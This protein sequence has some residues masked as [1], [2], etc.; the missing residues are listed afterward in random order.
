MAPKERR[1][2]VLLGA[3]A[4]AGHLVL[5]T[6]TAPGDAPGAVSLFDP[7]TD[8]DPLAHREKSVRLA[9]PLQPGERV[10]VDR[11][12]AEEL[13]RLPGVGP[14]LARRIVADREKGGAFGHPGGLDRVP[15][16]GPAM[17]ARLQPW[18]SFGG[19]P[20]EAIAV[21]VDGLID[22]NRASVAELDALPG[23]GATRAAAIVAFRDS[24][25]PFR[26]LA[27]LRQVPGLPASIVARIAPLL[28]F[29]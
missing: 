2:L 14:A 10:D 6:I 9:A 21:P 11:A 26:Q 3:L 19:R 7:A 8:G 22:V 28:A 18:L 12:P 24:V 27:D 5:A 23:I 25:G 17:L 15:G 13:A 20:A 4:L 16:V 1:A 29:R